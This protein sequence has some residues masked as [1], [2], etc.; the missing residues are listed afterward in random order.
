MCVGKMYTVLS[1]YYCIN[2]FYIVE[3]DI[4]HFSIICFDLYVEC[5]NFWDKTFCRWKWS[6][7]WAT[8]FL[9]CVIMVHYCPKWCIFEGNQFSNGLKMIDYRFT[10]EISLWVFCGATSIMSKLALNAHEDFMCSLLLPRV[11]RFTN[12]T[13]T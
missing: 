12:F 9:E 5:N 13:C 4:Y 6:Q 2:I 1:V 10:R 11:T 7:V 3:F 8:Y